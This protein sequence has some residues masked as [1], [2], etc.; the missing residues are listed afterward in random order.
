MFPQLTISGAAYARGWAYG[1]AVAPLIRHSIA[2]YARLFAMRRGM[3]WATSQA[4]ALRFVPLLASVAPDLL[5]EMRGIA[6]GAGYALGEIIAINVRTELLAGIAPGSYHLDGPAARARNHLAGVPEHPPE[7]GETGSP[8]TWA[9]D[10]GECTTVAATGAATLTGGTFLAQTW[11]WQG[12][13]RAECLLLRVRAPG[14]PEIL[15]LT[16]AG[17]LAKCGL[18][19]AGVAV[20]LNLLRSREDGR[21]V[22]MP[23]HVLL[24]MMLQGPDFAA[25]RACADL[26]APGASSC[27]TLASDCGDLVS[28]EITPNGVAEVP[29]EA[30]LLAHANHCLDRR[31][32]AGECPLEPASTTRERLGRAWDLLRGSAGR[33]DVAALQAILRDHEG[34]PR[35]ICRHPD[36]RV[37][38]LD[39]A[40]S[41][42][43]LVMDLRAR[44]M[45]VAPDVPC[46]A[47]FTPVG[48]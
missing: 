33:I 34:A 36:P 45:H 21:Q 14:E 23:V 41:I 27:I 39:R 44:V 40:E 38:R 17:M 29:A 11:D 13:Q 22:G 4:E 26:A 37:P 8:S 46:M 24:R 15:T 47:P 18:N 6:D 32:A 19:Q 48:L 12:D 31:A 2:S 9:A 3:D 30:E 1:A 43:G 10:D 28:L 5:E 25:A 42:C 16:E 35:C 7:P 20:A